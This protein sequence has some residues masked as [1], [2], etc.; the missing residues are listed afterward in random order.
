MREIVKNTK[1]DVLVSV[2]PFSK[3]LLSRTKRRIAGNGVRVAVRRVRDSSITAQ[4]PRTIVP[5]TPA[6]ASEDIQLESKTWVS[7]YCPFTDTIL[8]GSPAPTQRSQVRTGVSSTVSQARVRELSVNN[9]ALPGRI[10][11]FANVG[12]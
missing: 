3:K 8:M 2:S 12:V 5:S 7:Q 1:K 4:A 10:I 6:C 9:G 11:M